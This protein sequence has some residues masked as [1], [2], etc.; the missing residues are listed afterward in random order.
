MRLEWTESKLEKQSTRCARNDPTQPTPWQLNAPNPT[1]PTSLPW[2]GTRMQAGGMSLRNNTRLLS[3]ESCDGT[4]ELRRKLH[5]QGRPLCRR[6]FR[7]SSAAL[8]GIFVPY[9]I[10]PPRRGTWLH[11][12]WQSISLISRSPPLGPVIPIPINLASPAIRCSCYRRGPWPA[13]SILL[14]TPR[15]RNRHGGSNAARRPLQHQPPPRGP[16]QDVPAW[17]LL[18]FLRPW[19]LCSYPFCCAGG[20]GRK[21]EIRV[22]NF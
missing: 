7:I 16:A 13:P 12:R 17:S 18:Q 9:S 19:L 15:E 4:A 8:L 22:R 3:S 20:K 2:S 10:P 1:P 6:G 11:R 14:S 5:A 21:R